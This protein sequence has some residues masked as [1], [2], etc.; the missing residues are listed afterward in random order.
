[1][2]WQPTDDSSTMLL[3]GTSAQFDARLG[4]WWRGVTVCCNGKLL[5]L[6]IQCVHVFL[7]NLKN[8]GRTA[9]GGGGCGLQPPPAQT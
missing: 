6:P 9:K 2:T 7:I 4:Q 8:Q 5:V 1:M 3:V